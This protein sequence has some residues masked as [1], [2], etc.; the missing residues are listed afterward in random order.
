[1]SLYRKEENA[2]CKHANSLQSNIPRKEE[3]K[4]GKFFPWT[5]FNSLLLCFNVLGNRANGDHRVHIIM[6]FIARHTTH[7]H[8]VQNSTQTFNGNKQMYIW[9]VGNSKSVIEYTIFVGRQLGLS[10]KESKLS[11]KGRLT[12]AWA[13][14]IMN[15]SH[16]NLVVFESLALHCICLQTREWTVK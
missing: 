4:E 11:G 8:S 10:L 13:I 12:C 3:P 15:L 2:K 5:F 7:R 1:M 14:G 9:S 6:E 16:V